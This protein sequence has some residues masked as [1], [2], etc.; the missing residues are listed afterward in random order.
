MTRQAAGRLLEF[1]TAETMA[2]LAAEE[3]L[4]ELLNEAGEIEAWMREAHSR[5][6]EWAVGYTTPCRSLAL[7]KR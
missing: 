2:R 7:V 5:Q 3:R 4:L 1:R 6:N